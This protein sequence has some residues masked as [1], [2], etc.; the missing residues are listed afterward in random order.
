MMLNNPFILYG[1]ESEEYFCDRKSETES[2]FN[3]IKNG[4]N[5]ALIAPRRIGKTG[6]IENLFHQPKVQKHYYTF[7][8]DIYAT[9]NIEDMIMTMGNSILSSLRPWGT[10]VMRKF[11]D[12]LSSLRSGISFDPAGNP[13]WNVEVGDIHTP[14]TTLE[15]IFHYIETADKPCIVAIDEFQA[16]SNYPDGNAEALLRTYIQH[17]RNANFIFSGSQRTMMTE[18]FLNPSRPFYQSTSMMSLDPIPIDKY[19]NFAQKHFTASE[20]TLPAE[21]FQHVYE[22]FEGITWYVQRI[23][24]ELFAIT[25]PGSS[26]KEE[27]IDIAVNNILRANEFNYQSLLFQLPPKQKILLVAISKAGKAK[28]ITSADFI[29]R[30]HLP[31]TSS[32]QAAIKGLLEKNLITMSLGVYEVYDKFFAMW[33]LRK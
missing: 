29:R 28:N 22:Q 18:I 1:Y 21:I 24:N 32:V 3:L 23:M 13:S 2:L 5:V 9:K 20:K 12:I 10:K 14:R 4:N 7:I 17:C 33:L 25:S 11:T 6:L 31:S 8:I 27:M 16:V 15:E 30:W 19:C 26:C